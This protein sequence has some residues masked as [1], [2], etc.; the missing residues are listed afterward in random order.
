M[1][2]SSEVWLC[3][4]GIMVSILLRCCTSLHPYSGQNNPPMYGDYEA[5]RHWME[6]TVNLPTKQWYY[7]TTDNDL[8]YWGLDYPPL[9][10]YHSYI[11][12]IIAKMINENFVTL[13]KSRGFENEDHKLFM[14]FTVL[15]AD[16]LVFIP[17]VVAYFVVT[18]GLYRSDTKITVGKVKI[19]NVQQSESTILPYLSIIL[20]LLYPGLIL[21]DH[22]H[23][24]YNCVSLGF[25]VFA[26]SFLCKGKILFASFFFVLSL[27][28]KQ[29]ELYHAIPFFIYMLSISI[30]NPGYSYYTSIVK[31]LKIGSVVVITFA[32]I[33]LPF[34]HSTKDFL[35]VVHRLFPLARGVFEDK[36]GNVWC[37]MNTVYKFKEN[38]TNN[39]MVRYCAVATLAA[40]VPSAADLFLRPNIEKFVPSLINSSLAFFLF[41]FQVHEKSILLAAIPVLLYLPVKPIPC[42]WFTVISTFSMFPLLMKDRLVIAF[43]GLTIFYVASFYSVIEYS[44]REPKAKKTKQTFYRRFLNVLLSVEYG[45][46]NNEDIFKLT[47]KEIVKNRHYL[48]SL[49]EYVCVLSSLVG[50]GI[51]S[52]CMLIF[53]PPVRYPDLF[54]VLISIYSCIH[55][56]GFFVYFNII[57]FKIPQYNSAIKVKIS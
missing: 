3:G 4:L 55:F 25:L 28:Y 32:V 37:T 43:I 27:N 51:L 6:I 7:N 57:Q 47:I 19:T 36:V 56:L 1:C 20:T 18:R 21:I 23:F 42:F 41:S 38:F 35:Q 48:L 11:C 8:M 49:F 34:L 45:R 44:L 9:T 54:P 14:R 12:G 40:I 52:A 24:Q 46:A 13:H 17:S 29:M 16:L 53:E 10:A 31:L 50:S 22:G 26:V 5:Q 33:W 2:F 30:P 39:Q 15:I